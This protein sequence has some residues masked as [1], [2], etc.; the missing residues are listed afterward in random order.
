MFL[1]PCAVS[2]LNVSVGSP[3]VN[4]PLNSFVASVRLFM[5]SIADAVSVL[6]VNLYSPSLTLADASTRVLKSCTE[7]SSSPVSTLGLAGFFVSSSDLTAEA[8]AEYLENK[9]S[10]ILKNISKLL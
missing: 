10:N 7:P 4:K 8:Y 3:L 9:L 1:L 6:N 2:V 5:F